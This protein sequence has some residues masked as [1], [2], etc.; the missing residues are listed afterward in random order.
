MN[1]E[2][3]PIAEKKIRQMGGEAMGVVVRRDDGELVAVT[4][5]G[6]V[7]RLDDAV[8]GPV[9]D[10]AQGAEPVAYPD[11]DTCGGSMNYMPWHYATE[12]ERHL[13]ACNECCPKVNPAHPAAKVPEET[14]AMVD[15]AVKVFED[16]GV[17]VDLGW[18][19][20]ACR[21]Y[22]AAA[23]ATPQQSAQG[24][25]PVMAT[26]EHTEPEPVFWW[27]GD[28]SDLDDCVRKE[29]S[30]FH[31]IPLYTQPAA[32][33]PECPYSCGW[34]ALQ[35]II[36]ENAAYF[37]RATLDDEFDENIR[38]SGIAS[39]RYALELCKFAR[40]ITTPQQS[41]EP[42]VCTW[43]GDDNGCW[44]GSCGIEWYFEDGGPDENGVNHCPR[45]GQLRVN[46]DKEDE[47]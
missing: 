27:D 11:C 28:L 21:A 5:S 29:Q 6:R 47:S 1:I 16:A 24:A 14:E 9:G 2:L 44:K 36:T 25:E 7:T 34:P 31:T 45:C 42:A 23:S 43:H 22:V 12:T 33:V 10:S 40:Q 39:G 8:A 13:H 3:L 19:G 41:G 32:K 4:D 38:Q 30:A 17:A 18:L 26:L 37:A 15:A 46:E 20:E 35:T